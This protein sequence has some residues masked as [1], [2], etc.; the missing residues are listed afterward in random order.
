[1]CAAEGSITVPIVGNGRMGVPVSQTDG[2]YE[3]SS[4]AVNRQSFF[5]FRPQPSGVPESDIT[6]RVTC[7][8]LLSLLVVPGLLLVV[9]HQWGTIGSH[10]A[11]VKRATPLPSVVSTIDQVRMRKV[12]G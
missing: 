8:D 4:S 3:S 5:Q 11:G 7:K 9:V 6:V 10:G 2:V 12:D 1:M